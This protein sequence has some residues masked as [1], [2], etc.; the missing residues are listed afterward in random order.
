MGS[1]KN[2]EAMIKNLLKQRENASQYFDHMLSAFENDV[3]KE[4][5]LLVANAMDTL[6]KIDK[7]LHSL[8]YGLSEVHRIS[9]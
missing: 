4:N 6:N 5:R 8:G 9:L 2:S 7:R 1:N 3:T